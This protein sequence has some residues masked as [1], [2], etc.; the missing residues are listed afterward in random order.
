MGIHSHSWT[1]LWTHWGQY[2]PQDEHYHTCWDGRCQTF[3][4]G[5][6]A[7]CDGKG[8]THHLN[9]PSDQR[10]PAP[11]QTYT[12]PEA[13]SRTWVSYGERYFQRSGGFAEVYWATAAATGEGAWNLR[14]WRDYKGGPHKRSGMAGRMVFI[15]RFATTEE[16][17]AEGD[18]IC[19]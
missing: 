14:V 19:G 17:F 4:V 2:G 3:L 12:S 5:P 18:R 6:G 16:A 1:A 13:I 10:N 15:G 11:N 7:D 8:E 9:F